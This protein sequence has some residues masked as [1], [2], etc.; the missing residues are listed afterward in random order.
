MLWASTSDVTDTYIPRARARA[1]G[2]PTEAWRTSA[3]D[4]RIKHLQRNT[5]ARHRNLTKSLTA[6][7][8]PAHRAVIAARGGPACARASSTYR[9]SKGGRRGSIA[10]QTHWLCAGRSLYVVNVKRSIHNSCH[11]DATAGGPFKRVLHGG[12]NGHLSLFRRKHLLHRRA[13][14]AHGSGY[15]FEDVSNFIRSRATCLSRQAAHVRHMTVKA[16]GESSPTGLDSAS[17]VQ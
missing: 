5:R 17:A 2:R 7:W 13:P 15:Y 12:L 4:V 14:G 8:W 1:A 11:L 10:R 3:P 6:L 9:A 16:A